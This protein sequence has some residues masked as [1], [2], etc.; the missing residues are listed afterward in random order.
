[1]LMQVTDDDLGI[2]Q[3]VNKH[4]RSALVRFRPERQL[5]TAITPQEFSEL[6]SEIMRAADCMRRISLPPE[7][8][9]ELKK[10][11]LEYRRNLEQLKHLLPDLQ[12]RLLAEKSRLEVARNHVAATAAWVGASTRTF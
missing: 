9:A 2:L 8:A 4:L 10:E 6:T 3:A 11:S 1:M 12:V 7:A 5:C